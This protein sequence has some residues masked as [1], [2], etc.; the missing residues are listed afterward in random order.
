MVLPTCVSFRAQIERMQEPQTRYFE[1]ST[2]L[3][4]SV[5]VTIQS[6]RQFREHSEFCA[7]ILQSDVCIQS[8]GSCQTRA[9]RKP[10]QQP[11][12]AW[13]AG[14]VLC[15]IMA[16]EPVP[17]VKIFETSPQAVISPAQ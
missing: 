16:F 11:K 3:L 14:R 5:V 13:V 8:K 2:M 6:H 7:K 10:K 1:F 4:N 15:I 9:E 12:A 17:D